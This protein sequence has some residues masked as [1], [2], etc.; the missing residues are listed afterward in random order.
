MCSAQGA[1]YRSNP[2]G[3]FD[4]LNQAVGGL[5]SPLESK[6]QASPEEQ[7]LEAEA[8]VHVALEQSAEALVKGDASGGEH[9]FRQNLHHLH[10]LH[11]HKASSNQA[12]GES[13]LCFNPMHPS[14]CWINVGWLAGISTNLSDVSSSR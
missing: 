14:S 10:S 11:K 7:C 3:R 9:Y 4:P 2:R 12:L 5:G 1:G 8:K 13:L 6:L